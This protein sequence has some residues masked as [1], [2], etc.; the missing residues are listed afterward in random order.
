MDESIPVPRGYRV[1]F[2]HRIKRS[3]DDYQIVLRA[4]QAPDTSA[5]VYHMAAEFELWVR[6]HI[7]LYANGRPVNNGDLVPARANY[8][9]EL[10]L[11]VVAEPA[12]IAVSVDDVP[13]TDLTVTAP[14]PADSTEWVIAFS[15]SLKHGPHT[16]TVAVGDIVNSTDVLVGVDLGL[17][18]VVNFPN[19][20][21]DGTYFVYTNDVEIGDG[22]IDV[23][24][25]SGRK[26]VRL[27]IP[28]DARSPGEN[29][30]FWDGRDSAG[31]EIANGTYLYVIRINQRDQH[32]I[33]RGK[34]ARIK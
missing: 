14:E 24:T 6:S 7:L 34:L 31:D 15:K 8:R 5:G 30:V 9:V 19:P 29:A 3:S 20:F 26:V 21:T 4:F 1:T 2:G 22:T 27:R 10:S 28:P 16:I 11:P 13:V 23:Y 18:R 33:T 32:S 25:T 12:D 17:K